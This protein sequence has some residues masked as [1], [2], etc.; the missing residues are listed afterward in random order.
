MFRK[1]VIRLEANEPAERGQSLPIVERGEPIHS[2]LPLGRTLIAV[3]L[4]QLL[5]IGRIG[6][7]SPIDVHAADEISGTQGDFNIVVVL[8]L[9]QSVESFQT[10]TRQFRLRLFTD[11]IIRH[12]KLLD[13]GC[14]AD[15]QFR[16]PLI[17]IRRQ[18]VGSSV[19]GSSSE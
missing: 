6:I 10:Q 14:N 17:R 12:P 19:Y 1:Q 5:H 4:E 16:L 15:I 11:R 2:V 3:R 9:V 13:Q 8:R 18:I 7:Q